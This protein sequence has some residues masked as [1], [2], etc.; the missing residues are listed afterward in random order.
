MPAIC[1]VLVDSIDHQT[2]HVTHFKR[3]MKKMQKHS[4]LFDAFPPSATPF[5]CCQLVGLVA[6]T[7]RILLTNQPHRPAPR[8]PLATHGRYF[9]LVGI[10][11]AFH[12]FHAEYFWQE[13]SLCCKNGE[14]I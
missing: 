5:P 12:S 3:Y 4:L 11:M 2:T 10:N 13:G 14:K 6:G 9:A 1:L 8:T 7:L